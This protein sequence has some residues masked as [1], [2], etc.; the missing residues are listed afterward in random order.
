MYLLIIYWNWSVLATATAETS[1]VAKE[2]IMYFLLQLTKNNQLTGNLG[3]RFSVCHLNLNN[4]EEIWRQY[5]IMRFQPHSEHI[6]W[7]WFLVC[8]LILTK[9]KEMKSKNMGLPYKL[10]ITTINL[11]ECKWHHSYVYHCRISTVL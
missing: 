11:R 4:L 8:N 6:F 7:C 2:A 3:N 5:P 1:G 10:C 9:L